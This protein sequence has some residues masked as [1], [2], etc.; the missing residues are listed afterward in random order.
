MDNDTKTSNNKGGTL[1]Q[2]NK[3]KQ[4]VHVQYPNLNIKSHPINGGIKF[5]AEVCCS[6]KKLKKQVMRF[7]DQKGVLYDLGNPGGAHLYV[8][9]FVSI[10]EGNT[11]TKATPPVK[12]KE[13]KIFED[14]RKEMSYLR[15]EMRVNKIHADA[16]TRKKEKDIYFSCG[17]PETA[18]RVQ[19]HLLS[20][21]YTET[22]VLLSHAKAGEQSKGVRLL[23]KS[24]IAIPIVRQKKVNDV[25]KE[26]R[27]LSL[28]E[29][30]PT[31]SEKKMVYV[32]EKLIDDILA[33]LPQ[34]L[35]LQK[36]IPFIKLLPKDELM[37]A[38]NVSQSVT[39]STLR[40]FYFDFK[41]FADETINVH[42]LEVVGEK[43]FAIVSDR[44]APNSIG[45]EVLEEL[46][47]EYEQNRLSVFL[48]K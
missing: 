23:P 41:K 9:D 42:L 33:S 28:V 13:P 46:F 19:D 48:K 21:G 5:R 2:I 39:I 25:A 43:E 45:I 32:P 27:V 26:V 18:K 4:L 8:T 16:W 38:L 10:K 29:A 1:D 6:D 30:Q 31:V 44:I 11:L 17:N 35:L 3:L 20:L 22:E 36:M 34:E 40:D 12:K 15:S 24:P 14:S 47:N 37:S 7:L